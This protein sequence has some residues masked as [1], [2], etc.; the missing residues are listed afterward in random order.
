MPPSKFAFSPGGEQPYKAGETRI[1]FDLFIFIHFVTKKVCNLT[2][3]M[4]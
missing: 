2:K 4:C 3:M 1:V